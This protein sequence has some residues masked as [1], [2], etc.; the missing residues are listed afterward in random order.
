MPNINRVAESKYSISEAFQVGLPVSKVSG[1]L[2][3]PLAKPLSIFCWLSVSVG[4]HKEHT[5]GLVGA[6]NEE[7]NKQKEENEMSSYVIFSLNNKACN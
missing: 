4:G 6:L 1:R 2:F 5:H 3:Q 7:I